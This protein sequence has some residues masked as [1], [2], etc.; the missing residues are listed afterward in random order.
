MYELLWEAGRI[1]S[2]GKDT[3]LFWKLNIDLPMQTA[4]QFTYCHS[5]NFVSPSLQV[6]FGEKE[7]YTVGK[8]NWNKF[9]SLLLDLIKE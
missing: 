2:T 9:E 6:N 8:L 3:V 1:R 7:V 5:C 4:S